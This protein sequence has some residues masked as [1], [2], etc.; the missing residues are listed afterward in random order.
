MLPGVVNIGSFPSSVGLLLWPLASWGFHLHMD[1]M[2]MF[3]NG[4]GSFPS[5]AFSMSVLMLNISV[6]GSF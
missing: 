2:N 3:Y 1:E 6:G 4:C 5:F